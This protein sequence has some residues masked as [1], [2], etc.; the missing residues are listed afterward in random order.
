MTEFGCTY[1]Y[2][3]TYIYMDAHTHVCVRVS[4]RNFHVSARGQL[5]GVWLRSS[6]RRRCCVCSWDPHPAAGPVSPRP[7]PPHPLPEEQAW[8]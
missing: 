8:L 7:A 6:L 3:H 4:A 5:Q 2:V 1:M